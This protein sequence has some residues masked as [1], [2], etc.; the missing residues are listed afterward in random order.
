MAFINRE[1]V[2]KNDADAKKHSAEDAKRRTAERKA[3]VAARS[4][5]PLLAMHLETMGKKNW[6]GHLLIA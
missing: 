5:C 6:S 2:K 4:A 3:G 1:A